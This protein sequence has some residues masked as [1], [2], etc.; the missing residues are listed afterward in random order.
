MLNFITVF[1]AVYVIIVAGLFFGQRS[2]LYFPDSAQPQLEQSQVQ[3]MTPVTLRTG[4]GLELTSWYRQA[5]DD[6]PTIIY[7]H[8]NAG[9]IGYRDTKVRPY[10]DAGFGMLLVG[11]RGYGGNPGKP[12]EEGFYLD[13]RAALGLLRSRGILP[14][15]TV[16]YGESLGSGVAVQMAAELAAAGTPAAALALESPLN[17]VADVAQAHYPFVPARLLVRD[18]FDSQAKIATVGAPLLVIHG[19]DDAVVPIRFGRKLF[20]AAVDP[21]EGKWIAGGNHNDLE[22]WGLSGLVIDFLARSVKL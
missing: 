10:L 22:D 16:L 12:T 2:L 6:K 13:G 19:E 8:G 9:N 21:K 14:E 3:D 11:Y 15:R 18:R 4:D 17:S 7:F 20:D 5:A 1:A